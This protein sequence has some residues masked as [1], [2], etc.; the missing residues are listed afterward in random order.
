MR[1]LAILSVLAL[2]ALTG[3][4]SAGSADNQTLKFN[5]PVIRELT[6]DHSGAN[7]GGISFTF[8]AAD[9]SYTGNVSNEKSAADTLSV[10]TNMPSRVNFSASTLPAGLESLVMSIDGSD[11]AIEGGS[12][13]DQLNLNPGASI[14]NVTWRAKANL[15]APLT[16][17]VVTV[18]AT[19]L[20]R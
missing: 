5:I 1:Q 7:A 19:M 8:T 14:L 20:G 6:F 16:T 15:D 2:A 9:F 17:S 3:T 10:M 11:M 18:T 13:A 12:V 4:A